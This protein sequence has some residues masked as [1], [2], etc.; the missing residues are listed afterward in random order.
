MYLCNDDVSTSAKF[1]IRVINIP[2]GKEDVQVT[3]TPYVIVE[4]DGEQT[5]IYGEAVSSSFNG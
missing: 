4:I 3:F 1:A 5:T 2:E